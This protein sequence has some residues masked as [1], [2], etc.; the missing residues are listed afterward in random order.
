MHVSIRWRYSVTRFWAVVRS[1]M[2]DDAE[3]LRWRTVAA[4]RTQ[5]AL[6]IAKTTASAYC[7]RINQLSNARKPREIRLGGSGNWP[8][9]PAAR[10]NV[11]KWA[12]RPNSRH[13]SRDRCLLL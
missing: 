2:G 12:Y 8:S 1:V 9:D 3:S 10:L 11:R 5:L 4:E 13:A 7:W 6:T